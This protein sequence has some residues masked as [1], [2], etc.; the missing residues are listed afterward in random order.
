L[1]NKQDDGRE[2]YNELSEEWEKGKGNNTNQERERVA[3]GS[4]RK[5]PAISL[6]I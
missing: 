6:N 3:S 5:Q 2:A 4:F 1:E